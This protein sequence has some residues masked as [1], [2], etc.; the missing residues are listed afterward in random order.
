MRANPVQ[1]AGR[2]Y[3]DQVGTPDRETNHT[4]L[5]SDLRESGGRQL[6]LLT[7][8]RE[9]QGV[10]QEDD[11]LCA[12]REEGN[13]VGG[14]YAPGLRPKLQ[15]AAQHPARGQRLSQAH[16]LQGI[17]V[18]LRVAVELLKPAPGPA[19]MRSGHVHRHARQLPHPP[20]GKPPCTRLRY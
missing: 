5:G 10:A 13:V 6:S 20:S 4:C 2:R 7:R 12:G 15:L 1:H 9:V 18:A 3:D 14:D 16:D 11:P 8:M 19:L 17:W